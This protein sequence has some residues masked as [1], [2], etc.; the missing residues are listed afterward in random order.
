MFV[1]EVI[2]TI[3]DKIRIG[4]VVSDILDPGAAESRITITASKL[5]GAIKRYFKST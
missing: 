2:A 4:T 1:C 3:A 5:T